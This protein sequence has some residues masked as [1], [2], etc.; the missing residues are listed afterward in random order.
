MESPGLFDLRGRTALV[1]GGSQGIGLATARLLADRGAHVV[2]VARGEDALKSTGLPYIVADLGTTE[3][4]E[5]TVNAA[6]NTLGH[7]DILVC[8]LPSDRR[9][10]IEGAG[11][12]F[13]RLVSQRSEQ[14][15]T[16]C[17]AV[18]PVKTLKSS[19]KFSVATPVPNA[20][21]SC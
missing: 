17:K 2:C 6:L 20:I 19:M 15:A 16:I 11:E 8:N 10:P 4:C 12:D 21:W 9:N 3:G 1:T 13:D 18:M 7:V 14:T 5:R